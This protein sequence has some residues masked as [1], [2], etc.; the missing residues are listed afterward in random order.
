[1]AH[2][3]SIGC[4][5]ERNGKLYCKVI[6]RQ[7]STRE[8]AVR[9]EEEAGGKREVNAATIPHP[10]RHVP[11][12]S[13]T[14][15]PNRVVWLG[16][17]EAVLRSQIIGSRELVYR[18]YEYDAGLTARVFESKGRAYLPP[19]T[20]HSHYT[21]EGKDM[22]EITSRDPPPQ[23]DALPAYSKERSAAFDKWREGLEKRSWELIEI[24]F[25]ET[26][27]RGIRRSGEVTLFF[28]D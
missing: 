8:T 18:A 27:G 25:P 16:P 14:N 12:V 4:L 23:L 3:H 13:R 15:V 21:I 10:E 5:D 7:L 22:G 17:G 28:T 26:R 2:T 11:G 1:M 6:R 20:H 19:Y 9:R 24:A